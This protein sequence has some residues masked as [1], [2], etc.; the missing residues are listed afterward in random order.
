MRE[1][2]SKYGRYLSSNFLCVLRDVIPGNCLTPQLRVDLG[3]HSA[4]K[5]ITDILYDML[6]IFLVKLAGPLHFSH[7]W[8]QIHPFP[9]GPC[10]I[11]DN[12]TRSTL[13]M[14]HSKP[15]QTTEWRFLFSLNLGEYISFC[16]YHIG[17]IEAWIQL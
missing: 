5:D 13:G 16:C 17:D 11:S 9:F 7:N 12:V 14:C 3:L 1:I 2:T 4:V 8:K 10:I 15:F 6:F